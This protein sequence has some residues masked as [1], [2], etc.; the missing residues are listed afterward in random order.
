[1]SGRVSGDGS[2]LIQ[3]RFEQEAKATVLFALL[4]HR[5]VRLWRNRKWRSLLRDGMLDEFDLETLSESSV[6]N[7][8]SQS[9]ISATVC[10][11]SPMLKSRIIDRD[12]N[13]SNIFLCRMG[14]E[15]DYAKV[16]NSAS[17]KCSERL[18]AND[19]ANAITGTP[20]YMAPELAMG[21]PDID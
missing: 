6:R 17:L 14:N 11:S 9:S 1:M 15:Y 12:I 16:L 5:L 7:L 21:V 19:R 4:T 18:T 3:R 10:R 8:P 2:A 20:A 13:P